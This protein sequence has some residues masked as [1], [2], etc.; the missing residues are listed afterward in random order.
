MMHIINVHSAIICVDSMSGLRRQLNI[1][2]FVIQHS[3]NCTGCTDIVSDAMSMDG[4]RKVGQ[5]ES[6]QDT[7]SGMPWTDREAPEN[8]KNRWERECIAPRIRN[9]STLWSIT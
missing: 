4:N 7:T 6:F 8:Y 9:F 5:R 3:P 2:H 1:I